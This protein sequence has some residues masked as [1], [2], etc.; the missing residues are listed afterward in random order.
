ML[1]NVW[2][3]F[4]TAVI[5]GS[6]IHRCVHANIGFSVPVNNN[7]DISNWEMAEC[8]ILWSSRQNKVALTDESAVFKT[9]TP[10]NTAASWFCKTSNSCKC[11]STRCRV[12][13]LKP[14]HG[15]PTHL[16]LVVALR[17]C[18][19]SFWSSASSSW[20]LLL[21]HFHNPSEMIKKNVSVEKQQ[22]NCLCGDS[23]WR[24][25]NKRGPELLAAP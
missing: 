19:F 7:S 10:T 13:V 9:V 14:E 20:F 24:F 25:I 8:Y 16:K 11:A 4:K 18:C 5:R 6:C 21:G 12:T 15:W 1:N 23:W 17:K 22:W 3:T 2:G